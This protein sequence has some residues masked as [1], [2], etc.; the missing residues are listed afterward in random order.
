MFRREVRK[1][2]APRPWPRLGLPGAVPGRLIFTR[3]ATSI[4]VAYG[5]AT[6][7]RGVLNL[8]TLRE[9]RRAELVEIAPSIVRCRAV[10]WIVRAAPNTLWIRATDAVRVHGATPMRQRELSKFVLRV[11][12]LLL[13]RRVVTTS[14]DKRGDNQKPKHD[15]QQASHRSIAN[16]AS[17]ANLQPR[18]PWNLRAFARRH[19]IKRNAIRPGA[20]RCRRRARGCGVAARIASEAPLAFRV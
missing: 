18:A 10:Q 20:P 16:S 3:A 8:A 5:C 6:D 14:G 17:L 1:P 2:P 7:T 15:P 13:T 4:D 11:R 12:L 19:D 9:H